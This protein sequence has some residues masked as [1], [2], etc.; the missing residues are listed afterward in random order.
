[1]LVANVFLAC[2]PWLV[3]LAGSQGGVGPVGSA[4][5][6]LAIALPLLLAIRTARGETLPRPR[7]YPL[8]VVAVG[9][10]LFAADLATW[11][12]GILHTR[13]ANATLLGN[14]TA[15]LFPT[16]GFLAARRWP[17]KRQA[18]ALTLALSGA[19]FMMGRSF[20]LSARNLAGDLLCV[21]AGFCYTGYLI[22][23]DRVRHCVPPVTLLTCAVA[24][25]APL[26]LAVVLATGDSIAPRDWIPLVLLA[27]GSQVIGQ[28]LILY[29]VSRAAPLLVGVLLLVQ[30]LIAATIGWIVYGE[31]LTA[32]DVAGALAIAAA[33]LLVRDAPQRLRPAKIGRISGR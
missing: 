13:L 17:S 28:G 19:G 14:V 29:A 30:P 6:R 25:G 33:V 7:G 18:V 31:R 8:A 15:I 20:E 32:A 9:G 3:R 26:L 16:Y 11:H 4:F 12:F 21:G 24:A 10:A 1:M 2:G 22:A 27:L 5:W 23:V